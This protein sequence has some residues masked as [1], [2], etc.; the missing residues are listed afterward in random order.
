MK[1]YTNWKLSALLLVLM[2]AIVFATT[3]QAA[4]VDHSQMNHVQM[5]H[6]KMD[7]GK[8]KHAQMDHSQ[9]GHS[10]MKSAQSTEQSALEG[11][12]AV[13]MSGRARE[14]GFDGR[15]SMEPTS[16]SDAGA[17][18]CAKASRGLVMLDNAG[19]AACGGKAMGIPHSSATSVKPTS[20]H[21][22]HPM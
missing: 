13:P 8:M 16:V 11:L 2:F 1:I 18:Q 7:H 4:E 20:G 17:T 14:A 6:S 9:M 22:G 5:S 19:W 10:K 12:A 3:A 15:Y 21:A